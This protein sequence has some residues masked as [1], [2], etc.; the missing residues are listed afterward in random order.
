MD[1]V[2]IAKVVTFFVINL[3]VYEVIVFGL[4]VVV[5]IPFCSERCKLPET[6]V[7][8]IVRHVINICFSIVIIL[9]ALYVFGIFRLIPMPG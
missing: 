4:G 6:V 7:D 8:S 3:L 5:V 9:L 2:Y 1:A